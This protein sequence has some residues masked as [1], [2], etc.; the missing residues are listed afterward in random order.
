M[1]KTL[2]YLL[3][4][5][6]A[7]VGIGLAS[8]GPAAA[9]V[10]PPA[11][12]M[13][14]RWNTSIE[15]S[16]HPWIHVCNQSGYPLQANVEDWDTVTNDVYLTYHY[17]A[18]TNVAEKNKIDVFRGSIASGAC[19]A[20]YRAVDG[21][22]HITN[23]NVTI[24]PSPTCTNNSVSFEHWRSQGVGV[25]I[26]NLTFGSNFDANWLSLMDITFESYLSFQ[27]AKEDGLTA[28]YY[29]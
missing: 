13:P 28:D 12:Y 14:W 25:G 16:G 8:T 1:R 29:N 19:N 22:N 26:G 23:T 10:G 24:N 9:S 21:A 5:I 11:P 18:C 15:I 17:G 4:V 6:G 20:V 7:V 3:A 27:P 2:L